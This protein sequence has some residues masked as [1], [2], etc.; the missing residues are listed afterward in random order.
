MDDIDLLTGI[1]DKTGDLLAGVGRDQWTLP[2]PCPEYDVRALMNHIVGWIQVFE[3]GCHGRS[4]EG[5][6][7]AYHCD[8]DPAGVFRAAATS[9]EAGWEK[10]GMDRNVRVASGEL[11][12]PMVFNMTVMEYLAHGWDLAV[13]TGQEVPYTEEE[14]SA[15]LTRAEVTLPPEYRGEGMPFGTVVEV[16]PGASAV[17]RLV[18]FLGRPPVSVTGGENTGAT[19]AFRPGR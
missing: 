14:A 3:A 8:D 9:L 12:G 17:T 2:T 19:A 1:L 5:D 10:Y 6:P 16:D 4:Y 18:A 11:P 7:G 13:A 15:T